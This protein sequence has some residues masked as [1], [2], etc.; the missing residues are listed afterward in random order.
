MPTKRRTTKTRRHFITAEAVHLWRERTE[1]L[2][3]QQGDAAIIYDA[4]LA[5]ALGLDWLVWLIMPGLVEAL[6]EAAHD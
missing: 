4:A 2:A 6:E 5:D 3:E 1:P